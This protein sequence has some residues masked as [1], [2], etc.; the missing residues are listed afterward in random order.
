MYEQFLFITQNE[1][2]FGMGQISEDDSKVLYESSIQSDFSD[3]ELQFGFNES[4]HI[5]V[6]GTI[7]QILYEVFMFNMQIEYVFKI[8]DVNCQRDY[9][10]F[11]FLV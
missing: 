2:L 5:L 8:Y 3:L 9:E 6:D 4:G 7:E 10:C 11:Q 1:C